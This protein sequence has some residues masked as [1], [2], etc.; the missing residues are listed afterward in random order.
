MR[1]WE[2]EHL[3]DWEDELHEISL[4]FFHYVRLFFV[5]QVL[6]GVVGWSGLVRF[7]YSSGWRCLCVVSSVFVLIYCSR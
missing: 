2:E 6:F 4:L 5:G 3:L 7:G 1:D